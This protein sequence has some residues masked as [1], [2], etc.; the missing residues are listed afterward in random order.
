MSP[1]TAAGFPDLAFCGSESLQ[2]K[3]VSNVLSHTLY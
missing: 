3:S 2:L 1:D